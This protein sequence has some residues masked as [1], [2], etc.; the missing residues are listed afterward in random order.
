[1]ICSCVSIILIFFLCYRR[2]N[3]AKSS[4]IRLNERESAISHQ[5]PTRNDV[6][7][8]WSPSKARGL[9]KGDELPVQ[10]EKFNS[11]SFYFS[12]L[13]YFFNFSVFPVEF[14]WLEQ[15]IFFRFFYY[16]QKQKLFFLIHLESQFFYFIAKKWYIFLQIL[17]F[18][19]WFFVLIFNKCFTG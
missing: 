9:Q 4:T 14:Y 6:M 1:V 17:L 10:I 3:L 16:Y 7:C 8:G 2:H 18:D 5:L 12:I 15:A 19:Q 13:F 11:A